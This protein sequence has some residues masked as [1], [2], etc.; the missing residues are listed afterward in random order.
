MPPITAGAFHRR[1]RTSEASEQLTIDSTVGGIAL[2]SAVY[3]TARY[4][5]ITF[6]T[7]P[8]RYT[9][10][11]T[12]PTA[13]YGHLMS[14]NDDIELESAEEIAGFRAIRVGS[15][16]GTITVTYLDMKLS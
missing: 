7:A 15:T 3:G 9:T 14:P 12:P 11:G 4:A 6:E 2:T 5:A 1:N 16:S 10:D 8:V 13:T